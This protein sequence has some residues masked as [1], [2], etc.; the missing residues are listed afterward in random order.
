MKGSWRSSPWVVQTRSGRAPH[1]GGGNAQ[2]R[3]SWTLKDL[4]A[5]KYYWSVQAIDTAFAGSPWA[6]EETIT[7]P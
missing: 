2:E 4:A 6:P 1:P 3:I 7:V 5:G